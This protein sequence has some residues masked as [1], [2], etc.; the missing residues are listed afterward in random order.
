MPAAFTQAQLRAAFARWGTPRA[1]R[2][3]NGTPWGSAGDLP[4]DLAL[5]VIGLGP[6][7]IWNPPR[8]PQANGV[9]ERSQGT[10]KR[11]AEPGTCRDADEL[12]DR[13]E[14]Q[15]RIQRERYPSI[16]GRSRIAAFP[17]LA[18]SGR[19]YCP[20]REEEAWRL[21]PVLSHLAEDLAVRRVDG[22]GTVSLYNRSRYVGRGLRGREVYISLDPISVEWVY[23][24][25]E[26]TCYRR[27]PAE[28]LTA[29]RVRRL[30][31]SHHRVRSR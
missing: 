27:Q 31:V 5:W 18:H 21:E 10:G 12:Q 29:E 4:T 22:S 1:V 26:G 8:C 2:V 11:W 17:A 16:A 20:D 13:L 23:A 24:G 6:A 3:D 14:R 9:V 30:E 7:M 15:D 25:A 19:A 28:E